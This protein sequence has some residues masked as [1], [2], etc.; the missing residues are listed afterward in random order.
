MSAARAIESEEVEPAEIVE[1]SMAPVPS[2]L[3][4]FEPQCKLCRLARDY[5]DIADTIH[6]MRFRDAAG[7]RPIADRVNAIIQERRLPVKTV[8]VSNLISHFTTH[9]PVER[10]FIHQ[11]QMRALPRRREANDEAL[12]KALATKQDNYEQLQDNFDKWQKVFDALFKRTGVGKFIDDLEAIQLS[13]K[14]VTTLKDATMSIG[15]VVASMDKFIKDKDFVL[16]VMHHAVDMYATQ[17]AY[18]IGKGFAEIRER[19]MERDPTDA[20]TIAWYDS[21][22]RHMLF[23]VVDGLYEEVK[24]TTMRDFNL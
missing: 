21:E 6:E 24:T 15:I 10:A 9:M 18:R 2:G 5:P 14:D 12:S 3:A 8:Y 19:L 16:E 11:L 4:I 1:K 17:I 23:Q 7:Y 13:S 20:T 22:I